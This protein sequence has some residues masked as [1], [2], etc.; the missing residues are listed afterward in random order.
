MLFLLQMLLWHYISVLGHIV[1]NLAILPPQSLM[2]PF[3]LPMWL[4]KSTIYHQSWAL[5]S[6]LATHTLPQWCVLHLESEC[7]QSCCQSDQ[8]LC[9]AV[10]Y[11]LHFQPG[12]K[13]TCGPHPLHD[14]LWLLS[15]C[16]HPHSFQV[17]KRSWSRSLSVCLPPQ[18]VSRGCHHHG[19]PLCPYLPGW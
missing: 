8:S 14:P 1:T 2:P 10:G 18:Q 7:M 5:T 11:G 4:W 13:P 16:A 17:K 12:P 3:L 9:R 19:T 6:W 15:C